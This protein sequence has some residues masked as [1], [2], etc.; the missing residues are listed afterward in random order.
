MSAVRTVD[1][2]EEHQ[3]THRD[4]CQRAQL[5]LHRVQKDLQSATNSPPPH[6]EPHQRA[7]QAAQ[8]LRLRASLQRRGRTPE[9]LPNH[10]PRKA[11]VQLSHL[12]AR[13]LPES[14]TR[15]SRA[16]PLGRG[17]D[18]GKKSR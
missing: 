13:I 5:P 15:R 7:E 18:L 16:R 9:A 6:P 4:A 3:G 1:V 10:P 2:Q 12:R 11:P 8:V 17:P 14:A